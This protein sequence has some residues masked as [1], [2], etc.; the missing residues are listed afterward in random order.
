MVCCDESA[1]GMSGSSISVTDRLATVAGFGHRTLF[2][3]YLHLESM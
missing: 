1:D 3:K 2:V